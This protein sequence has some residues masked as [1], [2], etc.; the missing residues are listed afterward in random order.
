[1]K[2]SLN[3]ERH[4]VETRLKKSL[5]RNLLINFLALLEHAV[6]EFRDNNVDAGVDRVREKSGPL[7]IKSAIQR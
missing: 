5:L 7:D 6:V 4:P 2:S 3:K 1:M